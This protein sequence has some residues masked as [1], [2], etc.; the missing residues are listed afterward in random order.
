MLRHIPSLIGLTL[1]HST[2]P[3]WLLADRSVSVSKVGRDEGSGDA[4]FCKV[5]SETTTFGSSRK[6]RKLRRVK[7]RSLVLGSNLI[8]FFLLATW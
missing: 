3:V 4:R 6:L 2:T 5:A 1:G 7:M 8:R